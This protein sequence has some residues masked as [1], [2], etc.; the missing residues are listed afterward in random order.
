MRECLSLNAR[1]RRSAASLFSFASCAARAPRCAAASLSIFA[2]C[3]ASPSF[4]SLAA[5]AASARARRA[6][7]S[8]GE[9]VGEKG[10]LRLALGDDPEGDSDSEGRRKQGANPAAKMRASSM[11]PVA[12]FRSRPDPEEDSSSRW[13]P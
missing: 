1:C 13:R 8:E 4:A 11:P 12:N 5:W 10:G 7:D 3:L 9:G 6:A 2:R